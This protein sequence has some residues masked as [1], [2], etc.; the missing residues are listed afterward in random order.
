MKVNLTLF[1]VENNSQCQRFVYYIHLMSV[2]VGAE[3]VEYLKIEEVAARYKLTE[4]TIY[5]H[6]AAGLFPKPIK[7]GGASRW[8]VAALTEW[9]KSL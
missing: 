5:R 6:V 8:S 7:L 4:R 3:S 1:F 2:N 9:E